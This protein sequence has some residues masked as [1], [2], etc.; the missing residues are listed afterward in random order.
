MLN[1]DIVNNKKE[2]KDNIWPFKVLIIEY[3]C[4]YRIF[5]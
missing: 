5:K 1:L 3:S 4:I 2:N